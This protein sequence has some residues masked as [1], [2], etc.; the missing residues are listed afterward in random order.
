[1]S[2][3]MSILFPGFHSWVRFYLEE[4]DGNIDYQGYLSYDPVGG[5]KRRVSIKRERAPASGNKSRLV[6]SLVMSRCL[7]RE[8][9]ECLHSTDSK[10]DSA[11][12]RVTFFL[13]CKKVENF[14]KYKLKRYYTSFNEQNCSQYLFLIPYRV[15]GCGVNTCFGLCTV[16]LIVE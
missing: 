12:T 9:S 16:C 7:C 15:Y 1:M 4:R 2:D 6:T 10:T 14:L 5:R 8:S 11:K 3:T 13:F